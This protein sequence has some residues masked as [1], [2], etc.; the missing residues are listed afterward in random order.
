MKQ[1][2][3]FVAMALGLSA[4][5]GCS[6]AS[7]SPNGGAPPNDEP[8]A[9]SP[10]DSGAG[11]DATT[12]S[13]GDSTADAATAVDGGGSVATT[14]TMFLTNGLSGFVNRYALAQ[15]SDPVLDDTI[16]STPSATGL[17]ISPWGELFVADNASGAIYRFLSPLGLP[18]PNGTISGVGLSSPQEMSFVDDQLWV[19][20]TNGNATS[21]QNVVE[22]AFDAQKNAS[23]TSV[24]VPGSVG[25]NRGVLW[26]AATRDLYVS[27]CLPPDTIQHYRV[28][29]DDTITQLTPITGNGLNNPGGMVM[30]PW[31][32]M[33]VANADANNI[34]RFTVDAMG[35][36]KANGS[37]TDSSLNF[38]YGVAFTPWNELYVVNQGQG[39]GTVS[40][41]AFDAAHA[42]T[43]A[44][45]YPLSGASVGQ[46][47]GFG[48][49]LIVPGSSTNLISDGGATDAGVLSDG[50]SE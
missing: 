43:E 22:L 35:N 25:C 27:Q 6:N 14:A 7:P 36:L 3:M 18:T 30:A 4:V 50:A 37:F 44:G 46:Q 38:P 16:P 40:R 26:V 8:D 5:A 9:S 28:G 24:S 45:T 39:T 34:L 31:G 41:F 32:E 17:A 15:E 2:R 48:W 33:F 13:D 23:G 12:G 11:E 21:P 49:I 47:G 42:S 29:A 19:P 1:S 10:G 20:N